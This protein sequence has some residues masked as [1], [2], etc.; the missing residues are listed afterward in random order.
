MYDPRYRDPRG[1]DQRYW[2]DAEHNPYQKRDGYP[3]SSRFVR[4]V[5][6]ISMLFAD[7]GQCVALVL[8]IRELVCLSEC[9]WKTWYWF[10]QD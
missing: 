10:L 2:Y 3:Y 8:V 9:R 7:P 6:G 4:S 5:H 1:Y